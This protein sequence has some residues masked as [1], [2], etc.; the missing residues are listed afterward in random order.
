[1]HVDG[2]TQCEEVVAFLEKL[3]DVV[4]EGVERISTCVA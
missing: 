3:C 1:M 4:E 2:I